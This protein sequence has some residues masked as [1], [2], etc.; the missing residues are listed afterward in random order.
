M[1]IKDVSVVPA[2]R[3]WADIKLRGAASA[4]IAF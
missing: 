2:D 4:N 3:G 1:A